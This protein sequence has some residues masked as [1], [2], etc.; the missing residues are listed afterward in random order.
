MYVERIPNRTSPPAILL[1]EAWREAGRV[2]KRTVANL[3]DWPPARVEALRRVLR[4]EPLVRADE[5]FTIETS[6]PH[7]HVEAILGM[8]RRL[9]VDT[10]IATKRSRARD[11][12]LAMIVER[13]VH[14]CSKLATTR[15]WSTT[16]LGES[17]GVA[18]AD[19]DELYDALDWLLARQPHI[20]KTLAARH[21][22]EGGVV[23]Y[24]V[25]SSY[26]EGRTCPLAH[27]GHDRD[28]K[29][30]LPII[31]YGVMT[32]AD[33]RPVATEVYAGN[34]GDPKT[35][36]DQVETL[37]ERFG[38]SHVVL[39]GDR[40]MLTQTQ[41]DHLK[42]YPGLGWISAL[43]SPAIRALV[44]SGTLQL[45]LFDVQH[46][47]EITSPAYPGERLVAC[48]NPLLAD[49]R[50]RKRE[51][52]LAATERDLATLARGA[53]RRTRTPFD[54]ATLGQKVGRVINHHKMAKHFTVTIGGGRLRWT[55]RP[56]SIQQE[57]RLDG[58]SVIR[59]SVPAGHLSA[60]D[61]VRHDKGLARVERA[62]RCLKGIDLRVRPIHHRTEAH[63]RAHIFLCLLAYYVEWHL[64]QAW[65]PLLFADE[66]LET[67]R[68]TRDP[69]APA[70][71]SPAVRRKKAERQTPEG[72]PL[73]S[74]DTLLAALGTR[75]AYRC[76]LR[77]DPAGELLRQ[78][79][80]PSALQARALALLGL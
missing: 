3:T 61:A 43:R 60:A 12:V 49:E 63:V 39:V 72:L 18:G 74:F 48:F 62:F 71:P 41:I 36:P 34:V 79:T 70:T 25:S 47:A 75:C 64:R 59:T 78:L 57:A 22:R 8:V 27:F 50:R 66:A 44:D 17:V 23:L 10:L 2:R 76:R 29:T 11:L 21:L 56:E 73:H 54:D 46:L 32:D 14:P 37:R 53:A 58:F 20:E 35:V 68:Q 45:S 28:G 4:D 67:D 5:L 9:G 55:R 6:L 77:S 16:T 13:L 52:L 1:R 69:V 33:G 51:D 26:Y 80:L 15:L 65:A 38:V 24:D 19:V 7:G 42:T 40:G 30:G 31:V